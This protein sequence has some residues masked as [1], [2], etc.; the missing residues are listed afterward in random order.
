M[1]S[2]HNIEET[3]HIC[4][5]ALKFDNY[6]RNCTEKLTLVTFIIYNTKWH[7]C[8]NTTKWYRL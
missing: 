4:G 3:T 2:R 7:H 1:L 8:I 5:F 6:K